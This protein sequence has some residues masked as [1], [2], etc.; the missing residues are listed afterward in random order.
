MSAIDRYDLAIVGSGEAGKY[1]AWTLSKAGHRTAMVERS[2]VG[3]SCPNIACL[4]SKNIIHS[5]KV[6][7]LVRRG[8]EFGL[9]LSSVSTNMAAVQRRKRSMVD[10]LVKV[11][12]DRYEVS[13]VELIMGEAAFVAPKTIGISLNTGGERVI[14][15]DRV[16]LSLGTRATD[17]DAPGL[18]DALPM[19]HVEVLD[20]ERV[21]KHLVVIGGGYVGLELAQAIRRFGSHVTVIERGPQL[22]SRE[23]PDVGAALLELFRDEG[24]HVLLN[25]TVT[26]VEGRSGEQVRVSVEH[27]AGC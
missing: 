9:A 27:L 20:L 17:P 2:M 15:A 23:D 16:V 8:T 12:L 5:A 3:G 7:S 25:A 4:P 24:I 21:P 6:A 14:T 22:A 18:V 10:A 19:T 26:G 1:L 13:A 11:H